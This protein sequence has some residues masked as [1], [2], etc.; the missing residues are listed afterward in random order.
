MFDFD[1]SGELDRDEMASLLER[2]HYRASEEELSA[3]ME[4]LDN[5]A[6]GAVSI[7]EFRSRLEQAKCSDIMDKFKECL[8]T[9]Q[10]EPLD[11]F[12]EADKDGNGTVDRHEFEDI[13]L[14][15]HRI[16]MSAAE[17]NEIFNVF[18]NDRNN[19]VSYR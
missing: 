10:I 6:S 7:A 12:Q 11:A 14:R 5:D 8:T 15:K 19:E 17:I 18:D 13:F 2:L 9:L 16:N 1:K 3:L 4:E